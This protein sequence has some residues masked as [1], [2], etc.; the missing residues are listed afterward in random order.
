MQ[1]TIAALFAGLVSYEVLALLGGL[2]PL[3]TL[4][5]VFTDGFTGGV[6]GLAAAAFALWLMRNAEFVDIV[7]ALR[8]LIARRTRTEV[9]APSGDEPVQF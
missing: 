5:V 3:E 9:L 1:G 7:A 4:R 8:R 6:V 2:A